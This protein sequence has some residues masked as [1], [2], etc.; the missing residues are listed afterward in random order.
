MPSRGWPTEPITACQRLSPCRGIGDVGDGNEG[1]HL[2]ERRDAEQRG[3]VGVA[4]KH[5]L[6]LRRAQAARSLLDRQHIGPLFRRAGIPVHIELARAGIAKREI[7]EKPAFLR[8]KLAARPV[9]G[10]PRIR[11]HAVVWRGDGRVVIAEHG[12]RSALDKLHDLG[13]RP[14]RIGAVTNVIAEQ[15]VALRTARARVIEACTERLPVRVHVRHQGNQHFLP[16]VAFFVL[17]K[18]QHRPVWASL[19]P[20]TGRTFRR[21]R[22][23]MVRLRR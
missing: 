14:C 3:P 15:D 21:H 13:H 7:G 1:G 11:V 23:P 12:G 9:D 16:L 17:F 19:I 5:D 10:G 20:R 2:G 18:W 4:A 6:R 8:A 22:I